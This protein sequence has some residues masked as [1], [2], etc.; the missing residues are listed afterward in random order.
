[1]YRTAIQPIRIESSLFG[2]VT[3]SLSPGYRA[4]SNWMDYLGAQPRARPLVTSQT[5][6]KLLKV[7]GIIWISRHRRQNHPLGIW[8]PDSE[9]PL[10]TKQLRESPVPPKAKGSRMNSH[11]CIVVSTTELCL[12][13]RV[14]HCTTWYRVKVPF[15]WWYSTSSVWSERPLTSLSS[16]E[17]S[18][19]P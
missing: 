8:R 1:M 4:P 17:V 12:T 18:H 7:S 3:F 13:Q 19:L 5:M 16:L 9:D 6:T 15:S 2:G 14:V 10:L 11:C